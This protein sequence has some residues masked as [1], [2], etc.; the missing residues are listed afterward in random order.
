MLSGLNSA[1]DKWQIL[2]K[3]HIFSVPSPEAGLVVSQF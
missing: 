3:S 1:S 2:V